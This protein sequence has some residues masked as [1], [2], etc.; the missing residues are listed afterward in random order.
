MHRLL[1]AKYFTEQSEVHHDFKHLQVAVCIKGLKNL[2]ILPT[3]QTIL[4]TNQIQIVQ[5]KNAIDYCIE[6]F[7]KESLVE[8]PEE[9]EKPL[10][11]APPPTPKRKKGAGPPP[12]PPEPKA[13][14]KMVQTPKLFPSEHLVLTRAAEL[15]KEATQILDSEGSLNDQIIVDMLVQYLKSLKGI[16]GWVVINF[17][18]TIEQALT[19]EQALSVTPYISISQLIIPKFSFEDVVQNKMPSNELVV[20]GDQ[21]RSSKLVKKPIVSKY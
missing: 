9:E 1:A 4:D 10:Q 2:D 11:A 6:V 3:L 8:L 18:E 13:K 16:K 15:G 7:K 17:P 21:K 19:L 14:S 5:T 20:S 12:P